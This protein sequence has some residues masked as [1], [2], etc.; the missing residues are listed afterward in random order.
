VQSEARPASGHCTHIKVGM[1]HNKMHGVP[2]RDS[3]LE[4]TVF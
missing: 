4:W 2:L 3:A 1:T